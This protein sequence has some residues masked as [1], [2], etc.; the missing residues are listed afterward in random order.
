MASDRLN[1]VLEST[2]GLT[3]ASVYARCIDY[4]M[5]KHEAEDGIRSLIV[6]LENNMALSK[7]GKQVERII[8]AT[9]NSR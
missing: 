4:G 5:L 1:R 8:Q 7:A 3:Y 2:Y 6:E 9:M